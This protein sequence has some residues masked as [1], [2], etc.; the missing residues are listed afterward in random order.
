MQDG[1]LKHNTI[2]LSFKIFEELVFDWNLNGYNKKMTDE[3]NLEEDEFTYSDKDEQA[4]NDKN[5]FTYH[6]K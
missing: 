1:T 6:K 2:K 4:L 5:T 3:Q